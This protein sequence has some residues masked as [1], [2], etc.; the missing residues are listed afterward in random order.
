MYIVFITLAFIYLPS[1][2]VDSSKYTSLS[3]EQAGRNYQSKIDEN[4][5]SLDEQ[6]FL[7]TPL[8][9]D[10]YN[11]MDVSAAIDQAIGQIDSMTML[12]QNSTRGYNENQY[13]NS[14]KNFMVSNRILVKS[15]QATQL[16]EKIETIKQKIRTY[17]L[18]SLTAGLDTV[19]PTNISLKGASGKER[20]WESFFFSKTPLAVVVTNLHKIRTDLLFTKHQLIEYL[21]GNQSQNKSGRS[22]SILSTNSIA[23]EVL[24]TKNFIVGDKIAF[25]VI[26]LDSARGYGGVKSYVKYEGKVVKELSISQNGV[27]RYTPNK[28]GKYEFLVVDSINTASQEFAVTNLRTAFSEKNNPEVLYMGV[29]NPIKLQTTEFDLKA[30]VLEIDMGEVIPFGGKYYLRFTKEGLAHLKIYAVNEE[31]KYLVTQRTYEVKKTTRTT[32]NVR[33]QGRGQYFA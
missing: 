23:V 2:F 20:S 19:L 15:S 6:L 32:S 16:K 14:S 22:I 8:A 24:A 29:D 4:M 21:T 27:V 13:L 25:R 31:G 26:L 10:F 18:A 1:E 28:P 30:L 11:V 9:Q 3:L 33:R 17:N 7:N 5:A 12:L